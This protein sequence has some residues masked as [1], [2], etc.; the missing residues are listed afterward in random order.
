MGTRTVILWQ[1]FWIDCNLVEIIKKKAKLF[2]KKVST[3]NPLLSRFWYKTWSIENF[4]DLVRNWYTGQYT[5]VIELACSVRIGNILVEFLFSGSL[6]YKHP[7]T[8]WDHDIFSIRTEQ[9]SS[10][11]HALQRRK[12]GTNDFHNVIFPRFLPKL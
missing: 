4:Y 6:V 3:C 9:A 12:R 10:I 7:K 11:K 8:E 2:E 1:H 5:Y